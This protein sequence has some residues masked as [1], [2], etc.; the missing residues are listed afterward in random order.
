MDCFVQLD[1]IYIDGLIHITS[2]GNDYFQ[3]DAAKGRL[4]GERT[5]RSYRLG[6]RLNVVVVRVD[7]DEGRIDLE[8]ADEHGGENLHLLRSQLSG[9]EKFMNKMPKKGTN[10]HG[11]AKR[12]K[13]T[14]RK[15]KS[16]KTAK[17]QTA[18][19]KTRRS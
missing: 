2:L 3:F 18:V 9:R 15:S 16:K 17:K 13:T 8:L 6:D 5:N 4:T 11:T 1:D 7:V 19:K 12:G 10:K 14:S